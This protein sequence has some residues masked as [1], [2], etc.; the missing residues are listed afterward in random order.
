MKPTIRK[1]K[2]IPVAE[3]LNK[4]DI[5]FPSST[6]LEIKNIQLKCRKNKK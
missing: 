2:M 1:N 3:E 4:K 6:K 5:N